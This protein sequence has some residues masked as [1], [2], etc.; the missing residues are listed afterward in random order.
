MDTH[1]SILAWKIPR[2]EEPGGLQ[3]K[4]SQR[5]RHHWPS[6]NI[7]IWEL[8]HKEGWAP[9]NW[10]FWTVVLEK[11]LE[12]SLDSKEIKPVSSKG[13]QS[14]IFLGR[15]ECQL[16]L[17]LQYYGHLMQRADS[18][19]KTLKLGKTEG[20]RRRGPRRMRW[21]DGITDSVDRSLSKLQEIVEDGGAWVVT[22]HG[23]A[24]SWTRLGNWITTTTTLV[25]RSSTSLSSSSIYSSKRCHHFRRLLPAVFLLSQSSRLVT[26]LFVRMKACELFLSQKC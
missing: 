26:P 7:G 14:W 18:L 8:D 10:C 6:N 15:T 25:Q 9:K 1:S 2:T 16:Q 21:L 17:T 19:K 23:V 13:N 24:K 11:T 5:V 3:S 20:R 4:G 22:V 12:S